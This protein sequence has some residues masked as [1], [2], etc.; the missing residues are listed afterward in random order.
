[1][2]LLCRQLKTEFDLMDRF[3][4]EFIYSIATILVDVF[5]NQLDLASEYDRKLLNSLDLLNK[6]H[7]QEIS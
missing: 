7:S 1:M 5:N 6:K 2:E 4:N 3:P